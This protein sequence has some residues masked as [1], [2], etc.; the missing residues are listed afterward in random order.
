MIMDE[1]ELKE[2]ILGL[3]S[4]PNRKSTLQLALEVARRNCGIK[5]DGTINDMVFGYRNDS[6]NLIMEGRNPLCNSDEA[7]L[8]SSLLIYLN[9]LE[10]IGTLFCGKSNVKNGIIRTIKTYSPD[11][12][13]DEKQKALKNLR[14]S[15]AHNFGLVNI[16]PNGKPISKYMLIYAKDNDIIKLPQVK[17]NGDFFNKAEETSI[18]VYVYSVIELVETIIRKLKEDYKNGQLEFAIDVEEVK[19]RFTI[20]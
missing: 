18:K 17:W 20:L 7:D 19:S 8:F 5:E 16:T 9:C 2:L 4:N 13:S 10:Q 3:T 15:L 6:V 14:N 1:N 12:L 11:L